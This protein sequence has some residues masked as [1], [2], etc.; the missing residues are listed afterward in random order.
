MK[1]HDIIE[2]LLEKADRSIEAADLLFSQNYYDF[3]VSRAYYAMFYCTQAVLMSKNLSF[4]KHSAV[5][6]TFGRDFIKTGIFNQEL[7]KALRN[8][9]EARQTGDYFTTE[10]ISKERCQET[11]ESAKSFISET[12]SYLKDK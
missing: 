10:Q 1:K 4:S 5:I 9:F 8:A 7:Y 6:A 2:K 11:I 3:A 12:E